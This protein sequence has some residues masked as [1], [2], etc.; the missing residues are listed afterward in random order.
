MPAAMLPLRCDVALTRGSQRLPSLGAALRR[1]SG[2]GAGLCIAQRYMTNHVQLKDKALFRH[3]ALIGNGWVAA[4]SGATFDVTDPGAG[5]SLGH[6]ADLATPDVDR[7]IATAAQAFDTWKTTTAQQR[8]D[9]LLKWYELIRQHEDDL[10]TLMTLENGKPLKEARGEVRYAASFI[11]WFA[12]EAKRIQGDVLGS[13]AANQ[14]YVVI[15]QPLGVVGILTPWNFPAAMLTRKTGAALAAGCTVVAKPASETPF[16]ALALGELA[17]RAG[18]PAGVLN[19]VP[20]HANLQDVSVKLTTDPRVHKVSFTGSTHI[21]SKIMAQSAGTV[22]KLSLELGGN[23]PCIVFDDADVDQAVDLSLAAK[24]RNNGQTC[25]CVN[26]FYIHDHVYD[27]FAA[28]FIQR[29]QQLKV[30]HGLEPGVDLGPLIHR[31]GLDKVYHHVQD[32]VRRGAKVATGGEPIDGQGHFFQPTVLTQV[33]PDMLVHREETF[34]PVAPLLRFDSSDQVIQW[35]NSVDVGLASYFFTQ[36]LSRAWRVA[37]ALEAGMV[38]V[39]TGAISSEVAPF[40]GVKQSGFGREGSKYGINEYL[41][42][43]YINFN[44]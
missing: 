4:Q 39:N 37:E 22:K 15:K 6:V 7:A 19:V 12:G 18:I 13:P 27:E 14:R 44:I 3:Q 31:R 23:A 38:G 28:K 21:G 30:G 43:K 25:I 42:I 10:A 1:S 34:G 20:T 17:M 36:N 32:A 16:S 29:V 26:R 5:N 2:A 8:H 24:F 40:G 9:L 33:T 11:Q 35:A 41:N